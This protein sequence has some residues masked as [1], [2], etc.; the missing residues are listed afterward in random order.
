METYEITIWDTPT[1]LNKL[2]RMHWAARKRIK[3]RFSLAVFAGVNR[4]NLPKDFQVSPKKVSLEMTVYFGGR[5]R[6]PDGDNILK[7]CYDLLTKHGVIHDDSQ[8]WLSWTQP[9]ILR[10]RE[11]PRTEITIREEQI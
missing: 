9:T 8:E 10:D 2:L 7:D 1:S 5:G 6:L 4:S 11:N 3:E